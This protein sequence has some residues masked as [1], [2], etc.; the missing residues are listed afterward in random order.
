MHDL[1]HDLALSVVGSHEVTI[2]KSSEMKN[3]MSQIRRLRLIMEGK[4]QEEESDVLKNATRLRTILFE[5]RGF[6]FPG[7][8]NNKRLRVVHQMDVT[9]VS[10][11]KTISSTLKFK[12]MRYLDLSYSNLE[13]IHAVPIHQLYNLQTLSLY[14]SKN[15]QN[16]LNGIGSLINLRYLNLSC[17]DATVLPDSVTTLTSLKSL[18]I[19]NCEGI[20]V[21]PT[22]IGHLQSLSF[23]GIS[24]TKISELP[25]SV[26]LLYNLREFYFNRCSQLKAL[27]RDFG[28]LTQLRLLDLFRTEIT[29][30]P[31][32]L[33]SSICKLERVFL[34][35]NCKFP[36]DI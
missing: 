13:D 1:V 20:T 10:I 17:S 36:G 27:P 16:I 7:A 4:P 29:E 30:L 19:Y 35:G 28:A 9:A 8:L 33:T 34:W 22:N 32:S 2:L 21:L 23:L 14:G 24:F 31:E 6:V 3:D 12:H 5:E 15:V 25:D 18:N 26:C 11:P